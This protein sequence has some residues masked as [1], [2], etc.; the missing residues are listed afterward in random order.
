MKEIRAEFYR[1]VHNFVR[2]L[3]IIRHSFSREKEGKEREESE[4]RK[5][6]Y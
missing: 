6:G 3:E 4:E 1:F 5:E 2:N